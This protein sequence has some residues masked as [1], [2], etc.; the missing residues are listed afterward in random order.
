[1]DANDTVYVADTS[2]HRIRKITSAGVVTT[3]AGSGSDAF[4]DGA[5]TSASFS[6][7]CGVAVDASG[8]VYVADFGNDRVRKVSAAGVVT[9]LAGSGSGAFANGVGTGASF[10]SPQGVA[11]DASGAVYVGDR[12]NNR[13]RKITSAGVVTTLAGGGNSAIADGVGTSASF[14]T[15]VGVAV[16]AN[17][18]VYV[19]DFS[20]SRIRKITSAGVV[21]T[22]AGS[23]GVFNFADGAGTSA[24]F[25]APTGVAVDAKGAVYVGD[26]GNN[27]I[28][29]IS[30]QGV[31]TT[32]AGSGALAFADRAGTDAYFAHPNH[33]AVG[34]TS[35]TVYVADTQ[36]QRI[37]I[38]Q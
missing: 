35:G 18:T 13:I 19:A 26:Y 6:R 29:K 31:V 3:L 8:A 16:D 12:D 14:S 28:R 20:S 9:T 5:G 15:P 24:F 7:P 25:W 34:A 17:G 33:V 38:I 10:H 22:L 36:N 21:T 27:R 4:A 1:V 32:L 23:E 37:R 30:S 11:V 2:N